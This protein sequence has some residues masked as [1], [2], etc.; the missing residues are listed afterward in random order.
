MKNGRS[1]IEAFIKLGE[2]ESVIIV[3]ALKLYQRETIYCD[4]TGSRYKIRLDP[5]ERKMNN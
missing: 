3:W 4:K 2:F 5:S 1:P